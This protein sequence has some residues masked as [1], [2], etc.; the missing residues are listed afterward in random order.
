MDKKPVREAMKARRRAVTEE[1]RSEAGRMLAGRLLTSCPSLRP[2]LARKGPIAVY[3]ASKEEIDL[4]DFIIPAWSSGCTLVAPRWNGAGYELTRFTSFE[5]LVIGPHGIPEPPPGP[6]VRPGE[7]LAWLVPGLA[8]TEDGCRLG[9][10]G[11]WYDRLLGDVPESVPKIGIAYD[12]QIAE[13]LP[14]GKHDVRMTEVAVAG[15]HISSR[16][17]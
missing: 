12:F 11:G 10:G 7:V 13:S 17:K 8:F 14:V 3:L 6:V 4:R 9:Y 2:A 15:R 1:R 5:E 16:S